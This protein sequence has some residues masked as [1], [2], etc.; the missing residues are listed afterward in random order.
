MDKHKLSKQI[1]FGGW[2]RG[3]GLL[4]L[5]NANVGSVHLLIEV[6]AWGVLWVVQYGRQFMDAF[7]LRG[8]PVL[9]ATFT[10]HSADVHSLLRSLQQSTRTLQNMCSH[11]KVGCDIFTC[12]VV[13][14]FP[15]SLSPEVNLCSVPLK[16]TPGE[17]ARLAWRS[18]KRA[19]IS[20]CRL[21][22]CVCLAS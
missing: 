9:D 22:A 12:F 14:F 2:G 18:R 19:N 20:I 16:G 3:G 4:S 10:S 6:N 5:S 17:G 8:M 21:W 13:S 1:F 11:A 15:L 7:L